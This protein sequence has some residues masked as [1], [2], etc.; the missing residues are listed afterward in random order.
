MGLPSAS[1]QAGEWQL[2]FNVVK[3]PGE[4]MNLAAQYPDI[5]NR[6]IADYQQYSK[7]VG[8]VEIAPIR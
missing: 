7:N 2:L 8:V 6:M 3:D 4:T 1:L 5:L